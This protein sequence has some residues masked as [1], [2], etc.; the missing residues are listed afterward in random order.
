MSIYINVL[1]FFNDVYKS[2]FFYSIKILW[3]LNL[4]QQMF[5]LVVMVLRRYVSVYCLSFVLTVVLFIFWQLA[6]PLL[7]VVSLSSGS[8]K[9][10]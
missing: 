10:A 2:F 3:H 1:Y 6:I 7:L 5:L 9:G 4:T 8:S